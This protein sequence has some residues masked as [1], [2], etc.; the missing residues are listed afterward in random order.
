MRAVRVAVLVA[1][2]AG[3][4][5]PRYETVRHYE[6]PAG[7]AGQACVAG[8][9]ADCQAAWQACTARVEPQVEGRFVHD[10]DAYAA[11]LRR[12]RRDL[13]QLQWDLWLGWGRGYGGL[14]YS[15]WP[16][17]PWPPYAMAPLPPGDPPSRESVRAQLYQVQCRDDCGC[18]TK[19][20][21]CYT[22][23]GGTLRL[24]TRPLGH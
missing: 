6:P 22:G 21:A 16:Y 24:E 7:A 8:C 2:L 10:L 14:W 23:C 19:Y 20:D 12:Y 13:D 3:C 18:Q 5:T 15:S 4:T 11:D 9:R 17:H 1:L